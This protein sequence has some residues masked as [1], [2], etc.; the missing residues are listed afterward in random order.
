MEPESEPEP[1]S[2]FYLYSRRIVNSEYWRGGI[3]E[4]TGMAGAGLIF[5]GPQQNK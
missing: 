2:V 3:N 1:E 4:T 5:L